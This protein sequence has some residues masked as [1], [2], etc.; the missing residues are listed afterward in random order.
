MRLRILKSTI[1]S[2]LKINEVNIALI[3][4]FPLLGYEAIQKIILTNTIDD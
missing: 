3:S 2:S 1:P 4:V